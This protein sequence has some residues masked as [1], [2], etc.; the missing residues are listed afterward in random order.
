MLKSFVGI[1][2]VF[3]TFSGSREP[4]ATLSGKVT[5]CF[6]DSLV[7]MAEVSVAVFDATQNLGMVDSLRAMDA[8]NLADAAP[9]ALSR[10]EM[11]FNRVTQ[12]VEN[13]TALA[14]TTTDVN[15]SF[16]VTFSPVD[17][18]VVFASY[19]A[20]DEPFPYG[21]KLLGGQLSGS[22]VVDMSRGGCNYITP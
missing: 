2:L 7:N 13:S 19:D 11:Q 4:L 3:V 9:A 1:V 21:Y 18:V 15:G 5:D 22:V 20:E 8:L 10:M 12:L 16:E 6:A 17:S 14:R